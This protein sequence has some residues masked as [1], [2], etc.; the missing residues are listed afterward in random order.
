MGEKEAGESAK[1]R[2]REGKGGRRWE[3]ERGEE[4]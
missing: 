1:A 2:N 4:E 3:R